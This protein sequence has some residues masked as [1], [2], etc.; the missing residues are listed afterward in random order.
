MP[1]NLLA[2]PC[3]GEAPR[4]GVIITLDQDTDFQAPLANIPFMSVSPINKNIETPDKQNAVFLAGMFTKATDTDPDYAAL[5]IASYIFG[6]A[7]TSRIFA[8]VRVKDGLSYGASAGFSVPTKDDLGRYTASA[9]A[10]PQN[11]PKLEAAYADELAKAIKE[12]FT[13]DEVEKAKKAWLDSRAVSRS[14][15]SGIVSL[16]MSD[17]RWGRTPVDWD[18]KLEASVAALTPQQ[19]SEAFRRHVDPASI[20]FVKGGDFKKA[21]VYQ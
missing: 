8:R 7:P 10:A 4:R 2:P 9:T 14:E 3:L 18:A 21:G 20:S 15:D 5:Q 16:L 6:G 17:T 12:G 11:M 13:A 19:V 1:G